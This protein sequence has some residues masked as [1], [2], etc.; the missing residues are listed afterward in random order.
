V[1]FQYAPF[2][3]VG[4]ETAIGLTITELVSTGILTLTQMVE[5]LSSNPRRILRLQPIKIAAGERANLTI[6]DPAREWVVDPQQFKSRSKNTPFGGRKLAGKP[7]GVI[8]NGEV[9]WN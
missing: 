7:F 3:I 4:L 9:F 2:G 5:K 8:N 6:F 1:E